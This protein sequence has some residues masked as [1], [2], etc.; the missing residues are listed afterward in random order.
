MNGDLPTPFQ[1]EEFVG[2]RKLCFIS[3]STEPSGKQLRVLLAEDTFL[4][5]TFSR[6]SLAKGFLK[7][8]KSGSHEA[9]LG[10]VLEGLKVNHL[11][12]KMGCFIVYT[13]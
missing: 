13:L 7:I 4:W 5:N 8:I 1:W 11:G 3:L 12:Y 2:D 10:N 6:N 9:C